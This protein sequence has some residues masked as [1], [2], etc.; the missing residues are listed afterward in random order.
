[1]SPY[2]KG[3]FKKLK[4]HGGT[5]ASIVLYLPELLLPQFVGQYKISD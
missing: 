1:M 3:W 5:Q 4:L 2:S